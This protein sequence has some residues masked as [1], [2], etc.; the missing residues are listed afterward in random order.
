M[1]ASAREAPGA[2]TVRALGWAV[3]G[4]LR[5]ALL[6]F[7]LEVA[8]SGPGDPRFEGKNLLARN[9][10]VLVLALALPAVQLLRGRWER[11]PVWYDALYL[12]I[13][14]VDMVG[15]SLNLFDTRQNFDVIPHFHGPGAFA[16]MLA[17]A[18]GLGL[19]SAIALANLMHA[20]LEAQEWLGDWLFDSR[21]VRGV[22]DSVR[23]MAVGLVGSVVYP[24]VWR[25]LRAPPAEQC[26]DTCHDSDTM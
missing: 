12:S 2:D 3:N 5:L 6:Y 10:T 24:V 4:A 11:F 8:L 13:A 9:A 1:A 22:W 18:F 17:G 15:N 19:G 21:N 14:A 16:V 25:W 7:T 20:A 23:D 26:G